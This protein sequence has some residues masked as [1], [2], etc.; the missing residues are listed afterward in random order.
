MNV[1][2]EYMDI[3][4]YYHKTSLFICTYMSRLPSLHIN[5]VQ[6]DVIITDCA[7]I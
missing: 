4:N 7:Q 1:I 3:V 5:T 2:F 6:V